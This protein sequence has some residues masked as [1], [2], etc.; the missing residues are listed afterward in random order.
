MSTAFFERQDLARKRTFRLVMLFILGLA[1][2]IG[3][4]YLV[5]L[6][7][8]HIEAGKL[9]TPG[10]WH[11]YVLLGVTAA[12]LTVV[13]AGSLYRIAQL[14]SGGK[15]VALLMGGREIAPTTRDF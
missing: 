8:I 11:P 3:L 7:A 4:T 9:L 14:A 10:L 2:L 12:V 15:A 13:G 1:F 6:L 5:L